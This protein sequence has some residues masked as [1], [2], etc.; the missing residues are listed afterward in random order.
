MEQRLRRVSAIILLCMVIATGTIYKGVQDK[1]QQQK[2]R[3][4][5]T[6][7]Q[8]AG[9]STTNPDGTPAKLASEALKELET[10]GRAPKTGYTRDQFSDGWQDVGDCDIRNVVLARDL[11][12]VTKVSDTNCTV[13][14]GTLH[15]PYTAKTIQFQRGQGTSDD[16]QIDHVVAL[17]DAWQKGAQSLSP[18]L[19]YEFANDLLN[20]LAVDGS[21][22]QQKSDADAATWLPPNKDYRCRYV[23]RQIAVKRK[24]H[25]WVTE[26]EHDAIDR[27][28]DTCPTQVLPIVF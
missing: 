16:V 10:K 26:A 28:L 12:N 7:Q 20:L 5:N 14:T 13:L 19:R 1:I 17:S 21:A 2:Q 11:Q 4:Q 23:A 8:V 3:S 27:V 18:E 15:D 9:I 6:V 25:L 24:Y 22:N